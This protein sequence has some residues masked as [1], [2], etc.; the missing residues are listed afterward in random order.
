MSVPPDWDPDYLVAYAL[1][2]RFV[3]WLMSWG[4]RTKPEYYRNQEACKNMS[5]GGWPAKWNG[6]G[7]GRATSFRRLFNTMKA[8][9]TPRKECSQLELFQTKP[10]CKG[11]EG[12]YKN[13]SK[14]LGWLATA[15]RFLIA[16][17]SED[18][19]KLMIAYRHH[20]EPA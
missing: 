8:A 4:K 14:T 13:M 16:A 10:E 6:N 19:A 11:K 17:A 1:A 15:R 7:S 12:P 18:R 5:P 3:G 20:S 9:L 2:E